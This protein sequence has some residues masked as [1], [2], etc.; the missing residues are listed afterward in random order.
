MIFLKQHGAGWMQ[1][2]AAPFKAT[3][4]FFI[5]YV[6]VPGYRLTFFVRRYIQKVLLPAKSRFVYLISNRYTMHVMM[7]LIV[8]GV[9]WVNLSA[10]DVRAEDFGQRSLLYQLVSQ[11]DSTVLEVVEAGSAVV[12]LGQSSSYVSGTVVDARRHTDLD[13]L[14]ETATP[15]VG[16]EAPAKTVSGPARTSTETYVVQEGDTLG[17][18]AEQ[19]DLSLSTILWSNGLSYTST[20]QPDQELSIL[21]V[22]GVLYTV[23]SGDTLGRIARNY[24]VDVDIVMSQNG[25][26]SANRLAIGDKLLLPGGEPPSPVTTSR[27]SAS[28]TTLFTAPS[29]SAPSAGVGGWIWPTDWHTI[30]QY[31]GWRHTGVDID[32]D[33][34]TSSYAARGGVVIY[35]GWR[36]G[37]GLSVEVDHGDGYVTRYAHHS[38]N[39]VAVGDVVSAGQVLAQTGTTGRSTG[40]HL[41]FEVIRNGKF[42]NPL[43][44]VR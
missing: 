42:Q 39:Y 40:T 15:V 33:Y 10:R 23:K 34:T 13:F 44:Y 11:D 41:H 24:S 5:R 16:E 6:G 31:Y 4:L 32:G 25:L 20:I 18:I 19:Y 28:I 27:A 21:P 14:E 43:D 17:R 30:T 8:I 2:L 12:T 36:S 7:G 1:K 38:K 3:G 9:T 29:I 35:S 22:D 37:Y 26:E